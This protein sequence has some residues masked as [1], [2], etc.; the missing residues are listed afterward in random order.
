MLIST[1]HQRFVIYYFIAISSAAVSSLHMRSTI[2]RLQSS[3]SHRLAFQ[4]QPHNNFARS[5]HY[6][7]RHRGSTILFQNMGFADDTNIQSDD[8]GDDALKWEKMYYSS[9]NQNPDQQQ[10]NPD[11]NQ[12]QQQLSITTTD[13]LKSEI[14]VVTFDLDNTIWKTMV[15]RV[16]HVR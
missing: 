7:K 14:R 6:N 8:S 1:S 16:Y 13:P 3:F 12:K 4:Q 11:I 15:R 2:H 5:Y 9:S 10:Y